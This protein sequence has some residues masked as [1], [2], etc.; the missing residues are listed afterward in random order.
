MK[1]LSILGTAAMFMVGGGILTHGIPAAHHWIEQ[2]AHSVG[3]SSGLLAA[4][5]PTLLNA[6]AGIV[7]GA[8]ALAVVSLA[9]R[10]WKA[11]RTPAAS[12]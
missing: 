2:L 9:T 1:S 7:A 11:L 10:I 3:A 4:L 5:T 6:L 8:I 12:A